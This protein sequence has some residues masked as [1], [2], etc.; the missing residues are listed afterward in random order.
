MTSESDSKP[1]ILRKGDIEIAGWI[2]LRLAM[3]HED[4]FV[5]H[6]MKKYAPISQL[7]F[8]DGDA[9]RTQA[10]RTD[11][12]TKLSP[13]DLDSTYQVLLDKITEVVFL[14]GLL[15]LEASMQLSHEQLNEQLNMLV[16]IREY[17]II[18]ACSF[19]LR[20]RT[21]SDVVKMLIS[22]F[23]ANSPSASLISFLCR[24]ATEFIV[25]RPSLLCDF[26]T[27]F[28]NL[29]LFLAAILISCDKLSN[30][31]QENGDPGSALTDTFKQV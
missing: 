1:S 18:V 28:D 12:N 25:E 15:D 31:S 7:E 13:L 4:S 6:Y 3:K 20:S 29:H 14:N 24:T 27:T 5:C 2:S 10:T 17:E 22:T 16:Q 30:I 19:V 8:A 23:G 9:D 21:C 11:S 26:V